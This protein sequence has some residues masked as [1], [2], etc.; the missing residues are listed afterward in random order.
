MKIQCSCGVKHEFELTPE[1]AAHP[2][3]FVCPACGL[4]ASE[5]VDGLIRRELGQAAAPSGTP[6]HITLASSTNP[7]PRAARADAPP[8]PTPP[9]AVAA[10]PSPTPAVSAPAQESRCSKHAELAVETCRVC[11]KPI[12]AKC[13]ELFGYICSPLCKSRASAQ[14]ISIPVFK[15]QKSVIEARQWRRVVALGWA[16]G[17]AVIAAIGFW[18][19]F[20]WSGSLPR[21]IF[22]VRFDQPA[23]S[24]QSF[25]CGKASD[26]IVFLHGDTLARHD[27]KVKKE[28]WS[29]RLLDPKEIQAAVERER[30]SIQARIDEANNEDR[31]RVPRMPPPDRMAEQ[32]ERSEAADLSLHVRGQNV[33]VASPRKLV[34]YDW[35]SGKPVQE[36]EVKEG[37]GGVKQVGNELLLVDETAG[38]STVTH[39]DLVSG[40]SRT[41]QVGAAARPAAATTGGSVASSSPR[42]ASLPRG[43]PGA[44]AGRPMDPSRVAQQAQKLSMPERIA[45]PAT[46]AASMNQERAFREMDNAP[47]PDA[48]EP[49]LIPASNFS[50]VPTRDG[51]VQ[52]AVKLLEARVTTRSAMKPPTGRPALSGDLTAANSLGAA[53]DFLN[54]LQRERGGDK[55]QEDLSRY[56]VTLRR[57]G[58]D[59]E[60]TGEVVGPPSLYPLQSV[61]VLAPNKLIMVFDQSNK[62]LW[63]KPLTFNV[64]GGTQALEPGG[65]PY[66]QGPCVERNGSL[67]VYDEGVLTAFDLTSGNVR[68]RVPTVGAAGLFFDDTGM[69]YVNTT[70]ASHEKLTYS[71]Q[72]DITQKDNP[73]VMK[74]DSRSG[75]ILWNTQPG[76]LVNYA[77]GKILL[78]VHS[79]MP[80]EED[81][82]YIPD[83]GLEQRPYLQ[84]R[85]ISASDGQLLWEHFQQRAPL[86]IQFDKNVIRIV[87]KKE[88][89]VLKFLTL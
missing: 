82:P 44:D 36:L 30:K 89:Q 43:I 85:R 34:R 16:V 48:A 57:P 8:P 28:V 37:F 2:A 19:W 84:I 80:E 69:L 15:G 33:W 52:L 38:Q 21:P 26:Q 86:D 47:Q 17:L 18:A 10:H 12:C 58:A 23:Y 65:S 9:R 62:K 20:R 32:I 27:M 51:C 81:N 78:V 73:V 67:Y 70:S 54:E 77:S 75:K 61:N 53:N 71:R 31:D 3:K 79:F 1:L 11:G 63:E 42:G 55:V 39:I 41:E 7:P 6:V 46:L 83:T 87:F 60:W 25:I 45:L 74:V 76:G 5:F 22:S 64:V 49:A 50:L 14:G 72:I 40:Q 56:Q 4:D 35:D 13:M 59:G 66:G 88:V 24:G 29:C 68:W